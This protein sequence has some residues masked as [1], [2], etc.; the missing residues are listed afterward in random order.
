ML[1]VPG[2]LDGACTLYLLRNRNGSA[3]NAD[4]LPWIGH[5]VELTGELSTV[6]D[7]PVLSVD[8]GTIAAAR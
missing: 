3:I 4:V 5:F 6:G 2:G 7:L 8:P 1:A